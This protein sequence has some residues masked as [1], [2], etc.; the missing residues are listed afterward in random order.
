[1]APSRPNNTALVLAVNE[2]VVLGLWLAR[3]QLRRGAQRRES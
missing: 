2:G 1:M 3:V